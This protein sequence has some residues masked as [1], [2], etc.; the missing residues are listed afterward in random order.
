MFSFIYSIRVQVHTGAASAVH[1]LCFEC[2]SND[3]DW[4]KFLS[5]VLTY[6]RLIA[7]LYN[8]KRF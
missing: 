7:V 5:E 8:L 3:T 6:D 1:Y 4:G 2:P